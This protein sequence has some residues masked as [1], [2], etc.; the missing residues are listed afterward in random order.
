[1]NER[2]HSVSEL[3]PDEA[4]RRRR[5]A[6][7][8]LLKWGA[9]VACALGVALIPVPQGITPQSWRLLAIFVATIVGSIL[10]PVPGGAMVLLGISAIALTK[11]M[12]VTE[13]AGMSATEIE[14]LRLKATLL[15]SP[16]STPL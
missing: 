6:R 3:L 10:R 5:D 16:T 12:P 14:T 7:Y 4:A 13:V 15:T 8:K 9:V 1:M 2:P 11:A